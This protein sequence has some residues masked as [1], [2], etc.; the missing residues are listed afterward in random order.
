MRSA[1]TLDYRYDKSYIK[2]IGNIYFMTTMCL[3]LNHVHKNV[4]PLSKEA[5]INVFNARQQFKCA[6]FLLRSKQTCFCRSL[7]K[8][9]LF[10]ER[11]KNHIKILFEICLVQHVPT[12]TVFIFQFT[13]ILTFTTV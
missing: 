1:F 8:G 7:V 11:Q 2:L 6:I 12:K 13:K 10:L 4:S 9:F 5:T 3:N